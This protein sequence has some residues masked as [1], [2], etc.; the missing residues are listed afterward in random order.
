MGTMRFAWAMAGTLLTAGFMVHAGEANHMSQVVCVT[1][2]KLMP[3]KDQG[4][5]LRVSGYLPKDGSKLSVDSSEGVYRIASS[6]AIA[7]HTLTTTDYDIPVHVRGVSGHEYVLVRDAGGTW[8]VSKDYIERDSVSGEYKPANLPKWIQESEDLLLA[9]EPALGEKVAVKTQDGWEGNRIVL[10]RSFVSRSGMDLKK[11]NDWADCKYVSTNLAQTVNKDRYFRLILEFHVEDLAD[12]GAPERI[13]TF[14]GDDNHGRFSVCQLG[15]QMQVFA[16]ERES[17][18]QLV[19]NI[20]LAETGWHKIEVSYHD[21]AWTSCLDGKSR[22]TRTMS[23]GDW[24]ENWT[25]RLGD[26]VGRERRN[27]KGMISHLAVYKKH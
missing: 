27:W 5:T 7:S 20:E 11:S 4:W 3:M 13:L 21:G 9:W 1:G 10:K 8:R 26:E 18:D 2:Y 16:T 22:V 23:I 15:K 6:S 24:S 12:S 17:S 14:S 25:L 19:G